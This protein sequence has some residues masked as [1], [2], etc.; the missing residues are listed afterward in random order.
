MLQ[1]LNQYVPWNYV[2][3]A[4]FMPRWNSWGRRVAE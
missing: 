2:E 4:C 3:T 1:I